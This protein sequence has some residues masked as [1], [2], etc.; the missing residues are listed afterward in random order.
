MLSKAKERWE[1]ENPLLSKQNS[2]FKSARDSTLEKT[3]LWTSTC[4]K[5]FEFLFGFSKL[6]LLVLLDEEVVIL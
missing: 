4:K 6:V 5:W 1:K 3:F 2:T